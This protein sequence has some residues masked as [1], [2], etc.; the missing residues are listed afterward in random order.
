ML[1][2][3]TSLCIRPSKGIHLLT[4]NL[5]L[6]TDQHLT[7]SLTPSFWEHHTDSVCL[8]L[9]NTL[10]IYCFYCGVVFHCMDV[11]V[12]LSAH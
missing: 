10:E 1:I 3:I 9:A 11:P 2:K 12:C 5:D 8:H 4:V 7:T 6:L